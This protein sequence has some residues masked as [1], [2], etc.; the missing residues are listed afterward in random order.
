MIWVISC[1]GISSIFLNLM[2]PFHIFGFFDILLNHCS[3]RSVYVS[4][5][6]A[7]IG[8]RWSE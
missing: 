4:H 2:Q 7:Y 1:R 5:H 6:H 8:V 3:R